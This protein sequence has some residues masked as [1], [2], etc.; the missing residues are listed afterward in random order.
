M[1][2]FS[3]I[4]V[5]V[6]ALALS[7]CAG[8]FQE[9]HYFASF[10][11]KPATAGQEERP[12]NFFRLQVD[13]FAGF[14]AAR[15]IS[16][17]YDERAVDLFFN[18]LRP[19]SE[20]ELF[21]PIFVDQQREP[22][23]DQVIRPL[24]PASENGAFVMIL[25]SNADAVASTIGSFAESQA[26]ANAIT[27]LVNRDTIRAAR[28]SD[29]TLATEQNRSA[30]IKTTLENLFGALAS[31]TDPTRLN[32]GYRRILGAIARALGGPG[33]FATLD[34]AEAWFNLEQRR[35]G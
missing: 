18:E 29:A 19:L 26:V 7:G 6:I 4:T 17:F 9:R 14:S 13:G 33:S 32:A 28:R 3:T 10:A 35:G 25:S 23:T 12:V 34:E 11:N 2:V 30:A 31:E 24:S 1:R 20:D 22:G 15:Y 5:V 8:S 21:R 16:G 27:N